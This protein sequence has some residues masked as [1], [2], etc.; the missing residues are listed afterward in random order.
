M[1]K[2]I[3][4]EIRFKAALIYLVSIIGVAIMIIYLNGLRKDVYSQ[5]ENIENQHN[6]LYLT[7]EL[8]YAV[9]EAQSQS[10]LYLLTKSRKYNDS[11]HQTI[12]KIDSLINAIIDIHPSD[13]ENLRRI[14]TLLV[15]Q[16]ENIAKLNKL[17]RVSNPVKVI[18]E[19]LKKYEQPLK[20][21]TVVLS[22][23]KDTLITQAPRKGFMRRLGEVFKPSKDSSK[24]IIS[25][26]ID[27]IRSSP[28]KDSLNI[29]YENVEDVTLKAG[30][31]YEKSIMNIER[32]VNAMVNADMEISAEIS[33]FLLQFHKQ[34]LDTTL[35]II[36]DSE[37]AIDLD[38]KSVV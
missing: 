23:K 24:I 2:N 33:L 38:R 5:K 1:K 6:I 16:Y 32:Q 12:H 34:T 26:R 7:N 4:K 28:L 14:E 10:G 15:D 30:I 11:Y 18:S 9:N 19:K 27:T 20:N 36:E 25:E 17:L 31:A 35:S 29:I 21:D 3:E 8:V 22:V 37:T 13:E